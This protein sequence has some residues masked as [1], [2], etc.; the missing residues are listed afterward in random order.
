MRQTTLFEKGAGGEA[1]DHEQVVLYALGE[2]Q[3]RGKVLAGRELP[4]DRLR[5]ALRRAADAFGASEIEDGRA[6]AALG[7]L[8]ASVRQVPFFVAKHPFYVTV[9]K[10]L[11]GRAARFYQEHSEDLKHKENGVLG[12]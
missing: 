5:G 7:G 10:D 11:A 2:F 12:G 9:P 6:V 4:L 8:G 3:A 1:I